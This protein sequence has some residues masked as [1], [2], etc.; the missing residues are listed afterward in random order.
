[1]IVRVIRQSV[2]VHRGR[3]ANL[4]K[5][6]EER[7]KV[8]EQERGEAKRQE[9]P[10]EEKINRQKVRAGRRDSRL[11]VDTSYGRK[12]HKSFPGNISVI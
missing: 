10:S 7:E 6:K 9:T 1:M 4:E 8:R 3:Q 11:R 2:C 12:Q 5:G